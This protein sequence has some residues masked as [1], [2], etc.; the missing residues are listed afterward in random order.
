[1]KVSATLDRAQIKKAIDAL[2]LY[3]QATGKDAEKTLNRFM[4]NVAIYSSAKT[5]KADAEKIKAELATVVAMRFATKTGKRLKKAQEIRKPTTLARA[6]VVARMRR[7]GE[8]VTSQGIDEAAK[9]LVN[10]RIKSVGY[11][12][13][14]YIPAFREFG[15]PLSRSGAKQFGPPV[16]TGSKATVSRLRATLTNFAPAIDKVGRAA[17][18][19]AVREA[20]V[21]METFAKA[22]LDKRSAAATKTINA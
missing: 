1:M 8:S 9:K 20:T 2:R 17:F 6:I 15:A 7:K 19:T 22:Q 12:K 4:R 3:Q 21:D 11:H 16:G 18:E 5:P 10:G 14:G 13:A